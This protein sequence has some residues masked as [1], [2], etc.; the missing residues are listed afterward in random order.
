MR[1]AVGVVVAAMG[2]AM[3]PTMGPFAFVQIV[4]GGLL[5]Y[6]GVRRAQEERAK[7]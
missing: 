5:V 2:A 7:P 4:A 3:L 1:I 6:E